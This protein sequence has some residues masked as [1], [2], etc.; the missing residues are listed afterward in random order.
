MSREFREKEYLIRLTELNEDE[1]AP[2]IVLHVEEL[3]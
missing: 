1:V 2:K 3:E